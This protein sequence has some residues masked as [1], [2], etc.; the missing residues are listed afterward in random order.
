LVAELGFAVAETL[1]VFRCFVGDSDRSIAEHV[2]S[3]WRKT[4]PSKIRPAFDAGWYVSP[5]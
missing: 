2:E 1:A 3:M 5:D 4:R